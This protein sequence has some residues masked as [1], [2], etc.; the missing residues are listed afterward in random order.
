M[1]YIYYTIYWF[2]DKIIN[3]SWY[4]TPKF[5]TNLFLALVYNF[6]VFTLWKFYLLKT[7]KDS[8]NYS[9]WWFFGTGLV[10]FLFN[11]I[12]YD[13]RGEKIYQSISEYPKRQQL[14]IRTISFILILIIGSF[15]FY[16]G[17][18]VRKHNIGKMN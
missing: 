2:Y 9:E 1:K 16:L 6:F 8:I 18:L 13:Y 5:Y 4:D 14:I 11:R 7:V 3:V 12:Y 17:F 10:F 15:Y